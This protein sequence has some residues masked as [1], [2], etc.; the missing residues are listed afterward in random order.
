MVARANFV[1]EKERPV[2]ASPIH[3][4]KPLAI[5]RYSIYSGKDN[6]N[7]S[8]ALNEGGRVIMIPG[9]FQY[10]DA[11]GRPTITISGNYIFDREGDYNG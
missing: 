7:I 2:F 9:F 10:I 1:Q 8:E 4:A 11:E 6:W 5:G 3:E